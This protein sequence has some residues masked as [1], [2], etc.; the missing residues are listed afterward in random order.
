MIVGISGHGASGK[1]T[2]AKQL[3]RHFG[4]ANYINTDPYI[5]NSSVRKHSFIEY[6]YENE[7]HQSKM[8]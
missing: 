7:M 4:E 2:F 5:V 6:E 8:T 1:P 3:L